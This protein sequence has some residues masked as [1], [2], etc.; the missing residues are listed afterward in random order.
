MAQAFF[1]CVSMNVSLPLSLD[2]SR[3]KQ[4]DQVK[5][6]KSFS[7]KRE[8]ADSL[9]EN[10]LKNWTAFRQTQFTQ[11]TIWSSLLWHNNSSSAISLFYVN[12]ASLSLEFVCLRDWLISLIE[13]EVENKIDIRY[14][15][16]RGFSTEFTIEFSTENF[17]SYVIEIRRFILARLEFILS[18]RNR[19]S[20]V[21]FLIIL[22][23]ILYE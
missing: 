3:S 16:S 1:N 14:Y 5:V 18:G 17:E 13:T 15:I 19:L 9:D 10:V 4:R 2:G 6:K 8:K 12:D 23:W 22:V 11:V 21:L 7:H 20:I